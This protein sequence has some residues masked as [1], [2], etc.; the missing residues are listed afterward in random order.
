MIKV[1]NRSFRLVVHM[2]QRMVE[3]RGSKGSMPCAHS[4]ACVCDVCRPRGTHLGSDPEKGGGCVAGVAPPRPYHDGVGAVHAVTQQPEGGGG[5]EVSHAAAHRVE[6]DAHC[7][8]VGG[9]R[10]PSAHIHR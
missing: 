3:T 10:P 4:G 9:G 5:P 6:D 2:T 7:R 1:V 8:A